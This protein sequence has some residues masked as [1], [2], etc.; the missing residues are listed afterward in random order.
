MA[1]PGI[2]QAEESLKVE[3]PPAVRTLEEL[4]A[5]IAGTHSAEELWQIGYEALLSLIGSA[6]PGSLRTDWVNHDESLYGQS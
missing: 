3:K 2:I 1:Q 6:P 5:A 4:E